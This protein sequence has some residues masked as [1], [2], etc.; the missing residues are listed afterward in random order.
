LEGSDRD[1]KDEKKNNS[2]IGQKD[3]RLA[4]ANMNFIWGREKGQPLRKGRISGKKGVCGLSQTEPGFKC[5]LFAGGEYGHRAFDGNKSPEKP[6]TRGNGVL[7]INLGGLIRPIL[8]GRDSGL[9]NKQKTKR[10]NLRQGGKKTI[11]PSIP[12]DPAASR[13]RAWNT[14]KRKTARLLERA[15]RQGR[16]VGCKIS[17]AKRPNARLN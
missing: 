10:D 7:R 9:V 15:Q 11:E 14:T 3:N 1:R 13:D 6:A 5:W 16:V 17:T 2:L 4:V 12:G 8:K